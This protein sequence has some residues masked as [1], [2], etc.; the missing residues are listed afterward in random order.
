RPLRLSANEQ[1][2]FAESHDGG[3]ARYLCT[4]GG[5][6]PEPTGDLAS[7]VFD[8]QGVNPNLVVFE[9]LNAGGIAAREVTSDGVIAV[10]V[11]SDPNAIG[12]GDTTVSSPWLSEDGCTLYLSVEAGGVQAIC[13][14]RR[15]QPGDS[16]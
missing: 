12:M 10:D 16:G 2:V 5:C 14:L 8:A 15:Q 11:V 7:D 4:P 13:R 9:D 6:K 3:L 1:V